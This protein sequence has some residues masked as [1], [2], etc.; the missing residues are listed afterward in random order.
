MSTH[1]LDPHTNLL[2]FDAVGLATTHNKIF[3]GA[4]VLGFYAHSF[5][6]FRN[7]FSETFKCFHCPFG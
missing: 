7:P 4:M 5:S 2:R 1:G 3:K 6:I